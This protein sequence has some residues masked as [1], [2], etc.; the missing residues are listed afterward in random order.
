M[1][2]AQISKLFRSVFSYSVSW[3]D[4][5]MTESGMTGFY[6]TMIFILLTGRYLLAPVLGRHASFRA[7]QSDTVSKKKKS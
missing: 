3:F 7:G 2:I 5:L 4:T 1:D 6:F